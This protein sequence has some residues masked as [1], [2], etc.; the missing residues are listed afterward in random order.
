MKTPDR[1]AAQDARS[2]EQQRRADTVAS[3]A[4]PVT[5]IAAV[6][7]IL[8]LIPGVTTTPVPGFLG[9]AT[10]AALAAYSVALARKGKG[11]AAAMTVLALL[12]PLFGM[13]FILFGGLL[14][15]YV[16]FFPML[17]CLTGFTLG[18]RWGMAAQPSRPP[19]SLDGLSSCSNGITGTC[20]GWS[21][22]ES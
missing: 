2:A 17:V 9:N 4:R 5:V 22:S 7:A 8:C 13:G 11:T 3:I 16:A 12:I 20:S 14:G 21:E 18:N 15:Q 19:S 6:V 10:A 1:L